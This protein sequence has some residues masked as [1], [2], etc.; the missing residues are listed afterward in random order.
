MAQYNFT[1][2]LDDLAFILRQ[3]KIA[4]ESTNPD[5]GEIEGLPGL[6]GSPLLPFGL[7]TVD[8]SWNNLLPGMENVGAADNIMP[9]LV[10]GVYVDAEGRPVNFFFPGDPGSAGSSYAQ[11]APGNMVFDSRPRTV[12]NL[13]VDQTANNPAAQQA[14]EDRAALST[15]PGQDVVDVSPNGSLFIPNLSP[16]IG[17]SAPF[18]GMMALF[19]QFFDHG[20]DLLTKGGGTVFVPLKPDDPL[21]VEGST[22]NFMVLSRAA[23]TPA[24]GA[25]GILGTDDDDLHGHINTTTPFIDQN[26]TYT[27]HP[28]HQVFL[29]EYEMV[30]GRPVST[31]HLLGGEHGIGNW[32]EVKAQAAQLLGIQLVDTDVF[33][34]PLLATDRYGAFLRGP[35]GFVQVVTA[36]GLVEGDPAANDGLGVLLPPNTLRTGHA[37]LDDIAF[38]AAPGTWDHDRNPATPQVALTADLDT[39][40]GGV[41]NEDFD[42]TQPITV[43]N[44]MF[45]P[46]AAGTYDNELLDR[47]FITGDGRGNE[48]IGLTSIHAIFHSEHDRLVEQ[49]K[50]TLLA[51]GDVAV[52]NEWLRVGVDAVPTTEAGIA[53]LE[54]NGERLFQAG[55]FANEMEYQHL[56]F[57]EFARAAQPSVDPFVFSH[58]PDIDP[59]IFEEFANVVY[60]F[61]HS[62]L[63]EEVAR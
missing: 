1:V 19:G 56:V 43:N 33:N 4:E 45:L 36:T 40:T 58:S 48:N 18:N 11:T 61:G 13:I 52:L 50:E 9:R 16:D 15:Y 38:S 47:H 23:N 35:N 51:S 17:L 7:R 8:G 14:A 24:P 59:A 49:Y 57:E 2:N 25:D 26:Q 53:A 29:R 34:V 42:P 28:S 6:V 20:L 62:M 5:T 55:R 46:Q 37:F 63:T 27:S 30:D 54:W 39:A 21:Y 41:P 60:R 22:T 31:G 32:G 12:S 10:D 44:Q 3:I